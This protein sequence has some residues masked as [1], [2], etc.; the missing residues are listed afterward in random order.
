MGI[1]AGAKC[2]ALVKTV[3]S[4]PKTIAI[5]E[6]LGAEFSPSF[7][8]RVSRLISND[9]LLELHTQLPLQEIKLLHID[10]ITVAINGKHDR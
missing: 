1:P 10:G 6:L 4:P 2:R 3:P 9:Y 5:F 8:L 7:A